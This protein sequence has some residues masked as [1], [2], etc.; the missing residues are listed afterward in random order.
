[1]EYGNKQP[2]VQREKG[3]ELYEIIEKLNQRGQRLEK[4]ANRL[5]QVNCK[6]M[7][8]SGN[9]K[10]QDPANKTISPYPPG[11]LSSLNSCADGFEVMA[12]R[13]EREIG[14]LEKII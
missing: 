11:H 9:E 4:L 3:S 13:I 2:E 7:D 10:A 6:L 14:K 1:M 8:E 12:D 5:N